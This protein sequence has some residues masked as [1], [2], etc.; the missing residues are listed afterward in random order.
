M[1]GQTG[2]PPLWNR[3]RC[4]DSGVDPERE[5]QWARLFDE[6]DLNK[7]GRIDVSELRAGLATRGLLSRGS[8]EEVRGR[9]RN[10]SARALCSG[11]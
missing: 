9:R 11:V 10:R 3:A 4:S 5:E 1:T 7:D 8:V 6:L 2:F